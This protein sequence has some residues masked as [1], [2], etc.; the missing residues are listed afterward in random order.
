MTNSPLV[1]IDWQNP[2]ATDRGGAFA[3]PLILGSTSPRR[4]TLLLQIGVHP[5]AIV[6]PAIVETPR[7]KELPA[8][9]VKRMALEKANAVAQRI[10]DAGEQTHSF[11]KITPIILCA[12]TSVAVGRRIL[13]KPNNVDQAREFLRLLSGRRHQV[14]TAV[15][16]RRG[17]QLWQRRVRSVVKFKSLSTLEIDYF[18]STNDWQ[19]KAGGYAIQGAAAA[20]I[21]W[22]RGSYSAIAGLPLLETA[23]ML[24]AAGYPLYRP[25]P[26][27]LSK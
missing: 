5:T 26:H 4:R 2:F 19:G 13:G 18:L 27:G 23:H 6:A 24:M 8:L 15:V 16:V 9:Y 14:L 20:L 12:D 3:V 21:P 7:K 22:L 10:A 25:V 11:G 17:E 1:H